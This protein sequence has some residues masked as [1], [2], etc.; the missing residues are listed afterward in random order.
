MVMEDGQI[1]P[2]SRFFVSLAF[3]SNLSYFKPVETGVRS[4]GGDAW[5]TIW[6]RTQ[7]GKASG[8]LFVTILLLDLFNEWNEHVLYAFES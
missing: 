1:E 6:Q 4:F 8:S 2:V 5:V 3:S 7:G